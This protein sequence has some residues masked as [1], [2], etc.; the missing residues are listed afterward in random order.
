VQ[1]KGAGAL[2]ASGAAYGT[3]VVKKALP[4]FSFLYQGGGKS[5]DG[6]VLS[7]ERGGRPSSVEEFIY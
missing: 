3:A 7:T 5:S 2:N 4:G 1:E 6:K